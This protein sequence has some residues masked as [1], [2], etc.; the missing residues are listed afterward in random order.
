MRA[1]G[2]LL[3]V[4]KGSS[5]LEGARR[6]GWPHP[7]LC[8]GRGRCSTCRIWILGERVPPPAPSQ[9]ECAVLSTVGAGKA[10][11]LACQFR[12][13]EDIVFS[14]LLAAD[15]PLSQAWRAVR[16][17]AGEERHL[18]VMFVDMRDSTRLAERR[19]PF[20]TVFIVNRFHEAVGNAIASAG[21]QV[22]QFMGDGVMALFGFDCAPETAC[23]QAIQACATLARNIDEMNRVL[24]SDLAEPIRYGVGLQSGLVVLGDIGF[25]DHRVFTAIG[26]PVNTAARLQDLTKGM[27]CRVLMSEAVFRGA[28]LPPDALPREAV[29]LRGRAEP[30]EV[31]L[32]ADSADLGKFLTA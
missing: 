1:D 13:E 12:P 26:D 27:G 10:V 32:A 15:P 29:R 8:G 14:C 5:V 17:R 2:A 7:S 28:G 3:Q 19:L 23:R 4:P 11:R 21:G 22:N 9:A 25:R 30:V 16:R 18:V 24:Q 6:G 31:R 20:D